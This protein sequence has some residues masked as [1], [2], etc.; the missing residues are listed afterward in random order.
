MTTRF[1]SEL[2][3]VREVVKSTEQLHTLVRI[4]YFLTKLSIN[5]VDVNYGV[6]GNIDLRER[7]EDVTIC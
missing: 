5:H 6:N 2:K 4:V 7:I 3:E 1:K